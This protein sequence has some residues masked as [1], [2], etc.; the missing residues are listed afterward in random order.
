M[1]AL[2]P[3]VPQTIVVHLGSP[4]S[5]A[6]NVTLDFIDYIKNVASSELYPTWPETALRANIYAIVT[7]TL[8]RIYTE[9]Y[10]SQ[11]YNFDIT[12]NTQYDQ[13][14]FNGREIFGNISSLVDELFNDYI[15][16]S[17]RVDPL[18]AQYCNG[19]TVTCRGLSQWGTV[20]L[21][22]RGYTPYEMLQYY[23]GDD[24]EIV[25]NAPVKVNIPS[26]PG[27]PL[28]LGD[29]G[30]DVYAVQSRLNRIAVNYPAIPR[31]PN[32]DGVFGPETEQAVLAFQRIFSIEPV[33]YV[34][35]ATWYRI[36][37]TAAAVK[38]LADI[39]SEGVT[40]ND[41]IT[42]FPE[43]VRLGDSGLEV[44][45]MQYYLST[46]G[47]YNDYIPNIS[48]DGYFGPETENAVRAFQRY[49][50]LTE[51]G[52]VGRA[53]WNALKADY[54]D[55]IAAAPPTFQ[56]GE[57][58]LFPGT[59]LREGFEGPYVTLLQ[60]YLVRI[61][62][63]NRLIPATEVTGYFGSKTKRAV[64]AF[65]RENG[66]VPDGLVGPV[67]WNAIVDAYLATFS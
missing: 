54:A 10:R 46:I 52:I 49:S 37:Y 32:P 1:A 12:N 26:Y 41:A 35:K 17:G 7:F 27:A 11:G 42:P 61:S 16:R 30:N 67:L 25:N 33:G 50:G 40:L 45:S 34:G 60:E 13:A 28:R 47:L 66:F 57:T 55:I 48:I 6:P 43:T 20:S 63:F 29:I 4:T 22:N 56:S 2:L 9:W 15:R 21:A 53:T 59:F 38:R 5:N 24:I 65:Q 14:F 31:I 39:D 18:F 62:E 3:Y 64:S 36:A 8:N 58:V 44:K 19:T 51:D 23:Y